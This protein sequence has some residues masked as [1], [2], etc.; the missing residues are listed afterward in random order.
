MAGGK[1]SQ[2]VEQ[3]RRLS[4]IPQLKAV[5]S[6]IQ[7]QSIGWGQ[8]NATHAA[9]CFYIQVTSLL[10]GSDLPGVNPLAPKQQGSAIVANQETLAVRRESNSGSYSLGQKLARQRNARVVV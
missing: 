5:V 10:A 9:V 6:D 7:E 8:A 1:A 3:N 4:V 2:L